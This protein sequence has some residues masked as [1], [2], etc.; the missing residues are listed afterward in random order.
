MRAV[1]LVVA[2]ASLLL[3]PTVVHAASISVLPERARRGALARGF[4]THEFASD[5]FWLDVP[6]DWWST[7]SPT[8]SIR[9]HVDSASFDR[10]NASAPIF[11]SM[12]GEGTSG[13]ASCS[14]MAAARGALCVA[15]EHRFYGES[16]PNASAGGVS[17]ENYRAGLYVEQNLADTAAVIDAVQAAPEWAAAAAGAR[18][19]VINEGGSYSGATCAWFRQAYPSHTLGCVSSSGVVNALLDFPE[20]SR[21]DDVS[22]KDRGA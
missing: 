22:H 19:P 20:V 2:V 7:D 18:R 5:E 13:G 3:R 21:D 11:V 17:T 15:V 9:Y 1:F 8:F 12:G 10:A 6:L 4:D 16:V 14:A